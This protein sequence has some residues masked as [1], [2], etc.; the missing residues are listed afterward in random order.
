[1]S[2]QA[3]IL[4]LTHSY[5]IWVILHLQFGGTSSIST[6]LFFIVPGFMVCSILYIWNKT[7]HIKLLRIESNSILFF[8]NFYLVLSCYYGICSLVANNKQG[9]DW[10]RT[11]NNYI[12]YFIIFTLTF[13][14][15]SYCREYKYP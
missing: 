9:G 1:M 7:S 11:H 2:R 5:P 14:I 10:V 4:L 3:K 15:V 6:A 12:C 13:Y 8:I